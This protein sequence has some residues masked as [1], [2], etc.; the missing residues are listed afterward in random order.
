MIRTYRKDT[1]TILK[2]AP[3]AKSVTSRPPKQII[4]V[5]DDKPLNKAGIHEPIL[6]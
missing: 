6:I 3:L 1:G 4:L 2:V 5:M